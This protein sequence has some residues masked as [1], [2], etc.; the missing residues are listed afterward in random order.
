[1]KEYKIFLNS[2]LIGVSN[3]EKDDVPMGAVFGVIKFINQ[4]F[5]YYFFKD[6]CQSNSIQLASN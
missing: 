4:K 1:M 5:G 2:E 3:L 6:Y